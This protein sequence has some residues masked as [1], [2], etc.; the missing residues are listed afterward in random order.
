MPLSEGRDPDRGEERS[1][2][3]GSFEGGDADR[4][5]HEVRLE[6]PSTPAFPPPPEVHFQRPSLGRG[7]PGRA[8][9]RDDPAATLE[10]EERESGA[11]RSSH[12]ATGLVIGITFPTCVVVGAY[13][14]MWFDHR[15]N[16]SGTPWATVV[17]TL[18]GIAAGF[19]NIFRMISRTGGKSKRR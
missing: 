1:S 14:G 15:Y 17:M 10:A 11:P 2:E 5:E 12:L 7:A 16:P 18:A 8:F 3:D 4:Q 13:I 19:M 6:V 9:S